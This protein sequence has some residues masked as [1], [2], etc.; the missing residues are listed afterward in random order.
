[1]VAAHATIATK[2][3]LTDLAATQA[4]VATK[5]A[6]V[7]LAAAQTLIATKAAQAD[8]VAAQA[9]IVKETSLQKPGEAAASSN[10][11]WQASRLQRSHLRWQL[12]GTLP[13]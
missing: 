5:A 11:R 3:S 4:L 10:C 12:I 2:A 1:M 13:A 7:D 8:L 9:L 6:Q